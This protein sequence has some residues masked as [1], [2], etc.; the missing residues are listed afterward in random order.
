MGNSLLD[1]VLSLVRDPE[2]A[3]RY[4]ADPAGTLTAAGL[5]GVT[6]ADVSNLLPM[7]NDS[8]AMTTPGFGIGAAMATGATGAAGAAGAANVWASGAATAAFD[9]FTTPVTPSHDPVITQVSAV[10]PAGVEDAVAAPRAELPQ[11]HDTPVG[12]LADPSPWES[13]DHPWA[14]TADGGHGSEFGPDPQHHAH[15][16]D[17]TSDGAGSP[18]FDLF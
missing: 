17:G 2:V 11:P 12:P 5:T 16:H 15:G 3:D 1:F 6:T 10:A 18:G 8:L 13:P 4:A 14:A 7:V 9:A